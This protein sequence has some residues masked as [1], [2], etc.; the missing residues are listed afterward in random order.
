MFDWLL[1]LLFAAYFV[2]IF[3]LFPAWAGEVTGN[4]VIMW[5]VAAAELALIVVAALL[6]VGLSSRAGR[7]V[8]A[9][10]V[11][12]VFNIVL[13]FIWGPRI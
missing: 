5:S 12:T 11:L 9:L 6:P 4:Y 10:V 3:L 2:F 8:V 7:I 13:N 1:N